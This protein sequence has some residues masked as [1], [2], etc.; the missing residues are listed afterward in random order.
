ML[1]TP[2]IAARAKLAVIRHV[3]APD[4]TAEAAAGG[5]AHIAVLPG[6]EQAAGGHVTP[7][8]CGVT[9]GRNIPVVRHLKAKAPVLSKADRGKQQAAFALV[10]NGKTESRRISDWHTVKADLQVLSRT[11]P[12]RMVQGNFTGFDQYRIVTGNTT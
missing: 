11:N 12:G 3:F 6:S 9:L 10:R 8:K 4:N 5:F 7:G 1:I 2:A